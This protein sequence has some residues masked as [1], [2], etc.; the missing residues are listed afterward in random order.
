MKA[1]ADSVEDLIGNTPLLR[2][3]KSQNK[4]PLGYWLKEQ[5]ITQVPPKI[6]SEILAKVEFFNPGA[7]K[8][9]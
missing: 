9:A 5:G 1:I 2:I 4:I 7:S 8:T 3:K 6:Q